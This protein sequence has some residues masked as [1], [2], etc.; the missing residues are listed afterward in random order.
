MINFR[1]YKFHFHLGMGLLFSLVACTY[2]GG[3]VQSESDNEVARTESQK[4][5]IA[6]DKYAALI[7]RMVAGGSARVIV[8]LNLTGGKDV[9]SDKIAEAQDQLLRELSDY[10]YTLVRRYSSLPM[11]ALEV[12]RDALDYLISTPQVKSISSD[13]LMRPLGSP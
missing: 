2:G 6:P 5:K 1:L 8:E 11:L 13:S 3:E 12:R 9:P 4:G 10:R 7:A